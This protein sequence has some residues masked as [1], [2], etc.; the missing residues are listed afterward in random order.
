MRIRRSIVGTALV[1][2]LGLSLMPFGFA[3]DE[4]APATDPAAEPKAPE[5]SVSTEQDVLAA[6]FKR[7]EKTLRTM[8]TYY[9][10]IDPPKADLIERALAKSEQDGLSRRMEAVAGLLEKEQ[11]GSALDEQVEVVA[12]LKLILN[13]L[14]SEDERE[15]RLKYI[16]ALEE[17]RAEVIR[18][19]GEEKDLRAATMRGRLPVEG[20]QRTADATRDL[21]DRIDREDAARNGDS[22]DNQSGDN[23]GGAQ[24]SG[25]QKSGDQKSGDSKS[26]DSKSGDTE[27]GDQK[28]GDADSGDSESGD[29]KSGD[30]KS[31]DQKSGDA[32]SGDSEAGD[33]EAGASES[34]DSKSGDQKSGDSKSGDSKS[35]DSKSGDSEAGDSESG[36]SESG[37]SESGDSKSGDSK[38]G[39]SKSGDSKSGDSKSGNSESGDSESGDS[40]SGDSE[41]GDSESGDSKSGDSKSGDSK[42]GDSK[43]GDSKSGDSESGDSESGDRKRTPGRDEIEQAREEMERA[44]EELK[45]ADP[46]KAAD[47]QDEAITKLQKAK[48]KLEEILRQLREEER[49]QLL[50]ALEQRFQRMLVLQKEVNRDTLVL[51]SIYSKDQQVDAIAGRSRELSQKEQLIAEEA[52]KA[53][54]LLKEDGTSVSFPLSVEQ[55]REDMLTVARRLDQAQVGDLTQAIEKD[56]VEALEELIEAL[57][58]EMQKSDEEKEQQQQQ[59][60]QQ[61]GE[62]QDPALVDAIAELKMLRSLQQRINRRTVSLGT[63]V[64]GD[65]ALETDVVAQVRELSKRQ[66]DVQQATYDLATGRNK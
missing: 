46:D 28:S 40:E 33:S 16:E 31:G 21:R 57:Q 7:F 9:R 58:K 50:A 60:Q 4:P 2:L 56:I 45:K 62:P 18:I 47:H 39:D 24:K 15:E 53:L 36:D 8:A 55:L 25:D 11:F 5:V 27:S 48:E 29:Q 66:S 12:E 13:L 3:A 14:R 38:S 54:T 63:L 23:D 52:L 41:S 59:Q 43:S 19:I 44:I 22:G 32:K 35:G 1:A 20:Q 42:S 49:E 30:Q 34:G 37:D 65:Q 6:R 26:G 51:N 61:Q 64:E 10:T 17:Y